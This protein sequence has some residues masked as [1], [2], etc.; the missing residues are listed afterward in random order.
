MKLKELAQQ[1]GLSETTIS[2]ALN[3]FPEVSKNTRKRV[4]RAAQQFGYAPNNS[5][6]RLAIGR[7]GTVGVC[8]FHK[9]RDKDFSK[10]GTLISVSP[11][12]RF[13]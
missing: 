13:Q 9:V 7:A 2:R 4:E 1:L 5:A 8:G 6:R 12:Q 11:G 10:Y 3:G